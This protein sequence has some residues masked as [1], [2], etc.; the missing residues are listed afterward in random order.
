[1]KFRKH[2]C[3]L[4]GIFFRNF[5]IFRWALYR[6]IPAKLLDPPLPS[7]LQVLCRKHGGWIMQSKNSRKACTVPQVVT[8]LLF[9]HC[10]LP[11]C[12][13]TRTPGESVRKLNFV[14]AGFL[15][16]CTR[17]ESR[18]H[19]QWGRLIQFGENQ[20]NRNNFV[21]LLPTPLVNIADAMGARLSR[22]HWAGC[23]T[24]ITIVW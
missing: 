17:N 23:Q 3:V 15:Y 21:A 18:I 13:V 12:S 5:L 20:T 1:M 22:K 14:K 8:R 7:L 11:S 16:R 9:F 24:C 2:L 6:P 4:F 19:Y 10:A